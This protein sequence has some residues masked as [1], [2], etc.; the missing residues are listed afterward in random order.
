M[1]LT[2]Q[3]VLTVQLVHQPAASCLYAQTART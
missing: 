3:M 1:A 2:V